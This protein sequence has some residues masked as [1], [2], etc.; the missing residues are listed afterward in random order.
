MSTTVE[1]VQTGVRLEK[2][3]LKVLRALADYL[4]LSLGDLIEGIVLHAFEGKAAFSPQTLAQVAR[5][6]GVYGLTLA[7]KDS[8]RLRESADASRGKPSGTQARPRPRKAGKD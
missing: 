7:A 3:T 1:R 8:H 6:K 5:L 2:R 4:D